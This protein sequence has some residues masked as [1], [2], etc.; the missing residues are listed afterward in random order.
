ML[1][2][3]KSGNPDGRMGAAVRV[4]R[5]GEFSSIG[6]FSGSFS[7]KHKSSPF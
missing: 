1:H 4:T 6:F 5:L 7:E 2:Q 3:E